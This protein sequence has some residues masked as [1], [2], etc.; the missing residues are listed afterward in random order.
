[1]ND[2]HPSS[3]FSARALAIIFFAVTLLGSLQVAILVMLISQKNY[4]P[5]DHTIDREDQSRKYLY[6]GTSVKAPKPGCEARPD[7]IRCDHSAR[8]VTVLGSGYVNESPAKSTLLDLSRGDKVL[9]DATVTQIN[10]VL[11]QRCSLQ[12]PVPPP[13]HVVIWSRC[14]HDDLFVTKP[15]GYTVAI[16]TLHTYTYTGLNITENNQCYAPINFSSQGPSACFSSNPADVRIPHHATGYPQYLDCRVKDNSK[17][18]PTL[19]SL[20]INGA[21]PLRSTEGK[22]VATI[23]IPA[24][25]SGLFS[26]RL[27]I[28]FNPD[29]QI[30]FAFDSSQSTTGSLGFT[31][32]LKM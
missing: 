1:M 16:S 2:S 5:P 25:S 19:I 17:D 18:G 9:L 11:V 8:H 10:G 3:S 29:D 7:D 22:D 32:A 12:A 13:G 24:R 27:N 31:C 30:A 14:V 28:N 26:K 20:H 23:S 4:A 21:I 6:E 15:N